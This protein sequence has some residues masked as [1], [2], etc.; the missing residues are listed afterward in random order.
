MYYEEKFK[1][2]FLTTRNDK[3]FVMDDMESIVYEHPA[4]F[5]LK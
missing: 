1:V 5:F 2:I 3:S 4:K